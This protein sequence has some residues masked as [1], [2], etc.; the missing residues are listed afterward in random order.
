MITLA[1]RML[2]RKIQ[3]VSLTIVTA[4]GSSGGALFP[5]FVGLISQFTGPFVLNPVCIALYT[6]M[7]IIWLCLPN[8]ERP[9]V[10]TFR[11]RMW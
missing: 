3:V 5:F 11:Q 2:Q 9:R 8:V 4:F 10:N 7:L 6:A 1:V